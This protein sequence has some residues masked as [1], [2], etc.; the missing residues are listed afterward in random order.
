MFDQFIFFMFGF[1]VMLVSA[2]FAIK[3]NCGLC[4]S[5]LTFLGL[6]AHKKKNPQIG[7]LK[8]CVIICKVVPVIKI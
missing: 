1:D 8:Y 3:V 2:V 5:N 7:F 4:C 6:G